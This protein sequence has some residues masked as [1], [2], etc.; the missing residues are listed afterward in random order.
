MKALKK[1]I[2]LVLVVSL[3]T[4][5]FAGCSKK[6]DTSSTTTTTDSETTTETTDSSQTTTETTPEKEKLTFSYFISNPAG[7]TSPEKMSDTK[8]GKIIADRTGADLEFE[9]VVGDVAQKVG[10]MTAGGDYPDIIMGAGGFTDE[11]VNAKALI[12]L[13]DYLDKYPNLKAVY[14]DYLPSM[15]DP[16]DGNIYYLPAGPFMGDIMPITTLSGMMCYNIQRRVIEELNYP[17]IETVDD[18]MAVIKQYKELNPTTDGEDTIG[19]EI[20]N[21]EWRDTLTWGYETASGFVNNIGYDAWALVDYD[22]KE[23]IQVKPTSEGYY[24]M[25]KIINQAYADG[26]VNQESLIQTYDQYLAKIASG[27]VLA[28]IDAD[29]EY[30]S[31]VNSLLQEGKNDR[32]FISFYLTFEKGTEKLPQL[33]SNPPN[34][35]FGISV[36]AENVDRILEMFDFMATKEGQVLRQWGIEGEDYTVGANGLYE[37][38]ADQIAR[39]TDDEYK[40]AQGLGTLVY[41]FPYNQGVW[42]DGNVADPLKSEAVAMASFSDA[43]KVIYEKYG[44][45]LPSD[46]LNLNVVDAKWSP[47]WSI[48][49]GDGTPAKAYQTAQNELD[50]RWRNK[51]LTVSPDKFEETY[52][53]YQ[54]ELAKLDPTPFIDAINA[55]FQRRESN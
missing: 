15:K 28:T 8:I 21:H 36:N 38:S 20:L 16:V 37:K 53:E 3:L 17:K 44:W 29:W 10:V 43:Q 25:L 24:K 52:N 45:K 49:L 42:P 11:F 33:R 54:A 5:I 12:P 1:G 4:S 13:N 22:K 55:E 47:T 35:G 41:G 34:E 31:A 6:E 30:A 32:E 51:I 46:Q 2:M 18:F 27:R 9:Y 26:L 39:I 48:N 7:A 14:A 50:I 40:K 19:L 23:A